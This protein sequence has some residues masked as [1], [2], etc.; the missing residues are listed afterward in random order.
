MSSR[1]VIHRLTLS[2]IVRRASICGLYTLQ[3]CYPLP[4]CRGAGA[5]TGIS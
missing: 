2:S 4:S 5:D 3:H 1:P